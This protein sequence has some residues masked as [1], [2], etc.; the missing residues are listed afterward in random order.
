MD[1]AHTLGVALGSNE[2]EVVKSINDLL[3]L[4]AEQASEI[5]RNLAAVKPMNEVDVKN[6]GMSALQN[7]CN[8][9]M[10]TSETEG[11]IEGSEIED[12]VETLPVDDIDSSNYSNVV[13]SGS[14]DK[15]KRTWKRKVYPTSAVRRSARVR[16]KKKFHNDL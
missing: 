7:L 12:S 15:P 13:V 1:K 16:L 2:K 11:G 8:D 9:L 5:I 14:G 3:D 10:P 4:E 6:L